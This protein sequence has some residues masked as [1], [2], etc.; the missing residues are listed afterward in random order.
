MMLAAL[1]GQVGVQGGGTGA[2]ES[3]AN[4]GM[5]G[6]PVLENPVRPVISFYSWTE[7]ILS[8]KGWG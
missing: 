4:I 5:P 3:S 8:G 7:A 2:R 6:F 1:V